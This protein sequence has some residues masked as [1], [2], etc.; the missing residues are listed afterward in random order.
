M[1]SNA[2]STSAR[3]LQPTSGFD[4]HRAILTFPIC[5]SRHRDG[6]ARARGIQ[7]H[8]R[9]GRLHG[10][11]DDL[12]ELADQRVEVDLVPEAGPEAFQGL[13]RVELGAVE[14][15]LRPGEGTFPSGNN[16]RTRNNDAN[17]IAQTN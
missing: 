11:V 9:V 16:S 2:L 5:T 7:P 10:G 14:V 17:P 6:P 1:E 3:L 15:D 13:S 4:G 12:Q 8:R